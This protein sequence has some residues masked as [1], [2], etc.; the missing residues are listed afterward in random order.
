M[1][2]ATPPAVTCCSHTPAE[3]KHPFRSGGMPS[4]CWS[5]SFGFI[6]TCVTLVKAI[7]VFL[8]SVGVIW[9]GSFPS[10]FF[11]SGS[12]SFSEWRRELT[13]TH[14]QTSKWSRK[15]KCFAHQI[16]Q[17][18]GFVCKIWTEHGT[19]VISVFEIIFNSSSRYCPSH[20]HTVMSHLLKTHCLWDIPHQ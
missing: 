15:Q 12:S 5:C 6:F 9:G 17:H 20:S 2:V 16:L 1:L 18:E 8:K 13:L 19:K 7:S 14:T 4:Q 3:T 10:V 11:H